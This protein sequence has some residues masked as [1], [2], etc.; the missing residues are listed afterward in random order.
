MNILICHLGLGKTYVTGTGLK[1]NVQKGI[2]I[3][4]NILDTQFR[5]EAA[6]VLAI[7]YSNFPEYKNDEKFSEYLQISIQDPKNVNNRLQN[8]LHKNTAFVKDDK[9]DCSE[10]MEAIKVIHSVSELDEWYKFGYKKYTMGEFDQALMVFSFAALNGHVKSIKAAAY[11]WDK[12]L[13]QTYTCIFENHKICA[14][15]YYSMLFIRGEDQSIS[16]MHQVLSKMREYDDSIDELYQEIVKLIYSSPKF[17]NPE[18]N[19]NRAEILYTGFEGIQ[20]K[21]EAIMIWDQM[22]D[23]SINQRIDRKNFAPVVLTKYYYLARDYAKS[24]VM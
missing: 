18:Y 7:A 16:Y 12:N 4:E 3:L 5:S 9:G 14:S 23:D 8:Y 6:S 2:E 15:Y 10:L 17:S 20:N 21:T 11:I 24:F 19:F 22:I 1:Q 13:P